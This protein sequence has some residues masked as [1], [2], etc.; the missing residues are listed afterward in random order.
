MSDIGEGHGKKGRYCGLPDPYGSKNHSKIA[1]LPVLFDQ[2][3]TYGKGTDKGPTAL[4]EASRHLELYDIETDSQVYLEGIYTAPPVKAKTS[5]QMLETVYRRTKK[6]M[7]QGKF[8]VTLGGE[9]SISYAPIRAHVERYKKITILQFDAHADLAE[10]YEDNPWSHASAMARVKE[11]KGVE[12]IVSIGIRSMSHSELAYLDRPNTFFAHEILED[13]HWIDRLVDQLSDLVYI[14]FDLDVFDPSFMPST[15]T[16]EPGG[17]SWYEVL[18][19]L[20]RVIERKKLVGLDVVELL[21]KAA[22]RAP[23]FLAAKL[24]YKI[25]SYQFQAKKKK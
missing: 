21:P 18:K 20:K 6:L 14:T 13:P 10:A 1:L 23:D 3:T 24:I 22:D 25:L 16:P 9:H 17:L 15:G 12:K 2:T 19:V 11:L 7:D 5:K 4:I 8:V